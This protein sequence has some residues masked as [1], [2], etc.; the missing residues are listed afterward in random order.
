MTVS[1]T[2]ADQLLQDGLSYGHHHG[3]GGCVAEPHGEKYGAA[4]E[5]QYQ[6]AQEGDHFILLW[7]SIL[8]T[9][10]III[11]FKCTKV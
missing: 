4:H 5:A 9:F 8:T 6:P 11:V 7:G 10:T 2:G 3:C 1:Q